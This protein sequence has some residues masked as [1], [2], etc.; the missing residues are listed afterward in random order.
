MQLFSRARIVS[1]IA[2]AVCLAFSGS[3][4]AAL[5][6]YSSTTYGPAPLMTAP[7]YWGDARINNTGYGDY[8]N[9]YTGQ[10]VYDN[11][12]INTKSTLPAGF[13]GTNYDNQR[14]RAST[15]GGFNPMGLVLGG[16]MIGGAALMMGAGRMAN[17]R[18][19]G[20]GHS[21]ESPAAYQKA[22][23]DA[24]KRR[25][26][27]EEKIRGELAKAH[28]DNLKKRGLLPEP[29]EENNSPS[30]NISMG[31]RPAPLS[32]SQGAVPA[33][34]AGAPISQSSQPQSMVS[35][36]GLAAD[37]FKNSALPDIEEGDTAKA[38]SF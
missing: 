29:E 4:P 13:S 15:G 35:E 34:M 6:Q 21:T 20:L 14:G 26:T 17:L 24:E 16:G 11:G 38:L 32:Q 30:N 28:Q 1:I 5:A 18:A 9:P 19:G 7:N 8:R 31:G 33:Q 25:Q 10:P 27:Q 22:Q 2:I 23:K 3:L 12:T 36:S 37:K